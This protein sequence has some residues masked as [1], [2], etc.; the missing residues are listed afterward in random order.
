MTTTTEK[1]ESC[2]EAIIDEALE[3]WKNQVRGGCYSSLLAKSDGSVEWTEKINQNELG[4]AEYFGR[5]RDYWTLSTVGGGA[6]NAPDS[7]LYYRNSDGTY[8]PEILDL[9]D[10]G[11]DPEESMEEA[12]ET[13]SIEIPIGFFDDELPGAEWK[14]MAEREERRCR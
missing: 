12:L 2:R 6:P 8:G 3:A 13:L 14:R 7:E 10:A 5:P 4:E 9:M 1:R 11:I